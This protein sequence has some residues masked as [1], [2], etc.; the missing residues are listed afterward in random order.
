MLWNLSLSLER[1]KPLT[2]LKQFTIYI[3]VEKKKCWE[4][5]AKQNFVQIFSD[6]YGFYDK[7]TE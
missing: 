5:L 1:H 4:N 2:S 3:Y 7:V 6:G